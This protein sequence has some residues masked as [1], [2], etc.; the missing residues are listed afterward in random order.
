MMTEVPI[1]QE[2]G[3]ILNGHVPNRRASKYMRQKVVELKGEIDK[4][5]QAENQYGYRRPKPRYPPAGPN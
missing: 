5:K 3:T 2:D 4:Y 1:L